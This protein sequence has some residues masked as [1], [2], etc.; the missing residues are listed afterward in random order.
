MDQAAGVMRIGAATTHREVERSA[1]VAKYFPMLAEAYPNLG[2]V[3]VR[4]FGTLGGNLCHNA[5]GSDP[6]SPLIALG[7]TV[8]I[9]GPGGKRTLRLE[10]LG[11]GFYETSLGPK[12]ILTEVQVPLPAVHG[13]GAYLKFAM[14][15]NDFPFVNVAAH[16]TLDAG[17]ATCTD[18]CLVLGGVASTTI[19]ARKAEALLSGVK[20]TDARIAEAGHVAAGETDPIS[21]THASAEYRTQLIPVAVRRAVIAAYERARAA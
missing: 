4:N 14:R 7:A 2:S 11:T 5:P 13:A 10:D 8:T 19:R 9:G 1:L 17:R 15:R 18:V 20:L 21:D 6:P 16:I 3:Q 12:D